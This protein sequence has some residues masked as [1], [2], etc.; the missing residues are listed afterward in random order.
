MA[1]A[2]GVA[3]LAGGLATP[4]RAARAWAGYQKACAGLLPVPSAAPGPDFEPD[5]YWRGPVWLILDWLVAGGLE[6][7]GLGADA[8][9]VRQKALE[10]AGRG[11]NEYFNPR[12]G[13]PLGA[14]EFSFSAAVTLDL[15]QT[16]GKPAF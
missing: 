13:A 11:F 3:S 9:A 2:A 7:A 10:L 16:K 15:L 6:L 12:T 4:E 14:E 8:G 5:R 1:T